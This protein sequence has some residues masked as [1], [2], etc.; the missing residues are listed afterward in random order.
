[1]KS[2]PPPQRASG[3]GRST[4]GGAFI[5]IIVVLGVIGAFN[6]LFP[7]FPSL[8]R[9]D[10]EIVYQ[11]HPPLPNLFT[12]NPPNLDNEAIARAGARLDDYLTERASHDD[13]DSLVVAIGTSAGPLWFKGYGAVRANES[14]SG[15]PPDLDT[16][17]RLASVTKMF[18][19]LDTLILRD[20][21]H[22]NWCE[23]SSSF[24]AC[25]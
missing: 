19:T 14:R 13:I 17:Y 10:K 4:I 1:M 21:G 3:S 11:C 15:P 2:L 5:S 12:D 16:I 9:A 7:L 23:L 22:L 24:Q 6:Q 18:V 25:L 8:N 20:K